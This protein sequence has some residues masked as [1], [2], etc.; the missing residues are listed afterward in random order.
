MSVEKRGGERQIEG[1]GVIKRRKEKTRK[2]LLKTWGEWNI[3][4]R[5]NLRDKRIK[6]LREYTKEKK[7]EQD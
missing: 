2:K 4:W 1:L 5:R 3:E 7:K 6:K